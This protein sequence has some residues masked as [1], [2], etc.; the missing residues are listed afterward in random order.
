MDQIPK[1]LL[2]PAATMH[3]A[4]LLDKSGGWPGCHDFACE[5]KNGDV[6]RANPRVAGAVETG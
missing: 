2:F 5:A 6:V 4:Q 3:E 1:P